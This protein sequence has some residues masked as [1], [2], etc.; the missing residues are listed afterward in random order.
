MEQLFYSSNAYRLMLRQQVFHH[1]YLFVYDDK[2]TMRDFLK[3]ISLLF[4]NDEVVFE[5]IKNESYQDVKFYPEQNKPF[6]VADAEEVKKEAVIKPV[7][8]DKKVFV[9]SDF[10]DANVQ[11]QNK[12]L[13][14]IEEPEDGIYYIIGASSMFGVLPTILSRVE[15]IECEPFGDR[16]MTEYIERNFPSVNARSVALASGGYPGKAQTLI[17]GNFDGF[18]SSAYEICLADDSK[19]TEILSSIAET[20]YKKEYL[21]IFRMIFFDALTLGKRKNLYLAEYKADT[22]KVQDKYP[23]ETLLKMQENLG[24]TEKNIKFNGNFFQNIQSVFGKV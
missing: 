23:V 17:T 20:K 18:I 15:V 21:S 10:A 7:E 19:R 5:R 4:F 3:E 2:K 12:L 8:G 9:L 14:L 13:K 11:A 22:K 6:S 24:E 1:A 16:E